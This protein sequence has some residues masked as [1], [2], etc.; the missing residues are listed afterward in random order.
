[1]LIRESVKV[2]ERT[3]KD[4]DSG[5]YRVRLISEGR[6]SSGFY[7]G[8]MLEQYIPG[9]LP[10]GTHIYLDHTDAD[11]DEKRGGTRSI[12][13][14][15][16]YTVTDPEYNAEGRSME[17]DVRFIPSVR[18][19]IDSLMEV[20]GLS[21]EVHD[22]SKDDEDNITE[23]NSHPLNSVA[24]VP[25]PGRDG[26]VLS[27]VAESFRESSEGQDKENMEITQE[28]M[29]AIAASAA[30]KVIEALDARVAEAE[31][32]AAEKAAAEEAQDAPT[33]VEMALAFANSG[34]NDKQIARAA[35]AVESGVSVEDAIKDI[36]EFVSEAREGYEVDGV[37]GVLASERHGAQSTSNEDHYKSLV[38]Q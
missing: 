14:I 10:K 19:D 36:Q 24:L 20:V 16:G 32:V 34:L 9:A 3:V 18:E 1:M 13:D 21:I 30:T 6:G 7:K 27:K 15:V 38:K 2:I 22:A 12:R 23:L 4:A 37:R 28:Q 31:R 35:K 5:L 11:D 29:D 25:V 17:A 33:A 26:R 8:E